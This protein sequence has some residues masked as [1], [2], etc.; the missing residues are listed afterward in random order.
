MKLLEAMSL[1][2]HARPAN[3]MGDEE[4]L[5]LLSELDGR[6]YEEIV[7]SH[8]G[9]GGEFAGYDLDTDLDTVL[10]A[11]EPYTSVYLYYLEAHLDYRQAEMERYQNSSSLFNEAYAEFANWYNRT[12]MPRQEKAFRV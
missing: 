10:L 2:D 1:L 12:H 3:Q 4:K 11:P 8:E 7:C 9:A 6:I 5:R